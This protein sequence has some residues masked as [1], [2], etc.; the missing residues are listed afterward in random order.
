MGHFPHLNATRIFF[1]GLRFFTVYGPSGRPDMSVFSF[2]RNILA[3][4][5]IKLFLGPNNKTLSRDFTYVD[6]IV[7][8]VI[9]CVELSTPSPSFRIFN[10][11]NSRVVSVDEMVRTL[12]SL[13]GV[14]AKI[15][16]IVRPTVGEVLL[17]NANITK[18]AR[19]L[20]YN[21]Q[22]EIADGLRKWLTWFNDYT[23]NGT[24]F[25][26]DMLHYVPD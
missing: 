26:P 5:P 11:G 21:P 13:M 2:T 9:Q 7:R 20:Q 19:Y 24:A 17:T 10:L 25:K 3:G 4:K 14:K 16:Y 23:K 1:A 6:D 18:A 22:T 8:G 12:E 15:Q